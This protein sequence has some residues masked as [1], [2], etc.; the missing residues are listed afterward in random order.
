[1]KIYEKIAVRICQILPDQLLPD[2]FKEYC[3]TAVVREL[4]EKK[5]RLIQQNWKRN[6]LECKLQKLKSTK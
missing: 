5:Q 3:M 6:E 2:P 4:N 1:M